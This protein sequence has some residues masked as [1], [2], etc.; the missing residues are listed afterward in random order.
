[1]KKR[2]ELLKRMVEQPKPVIIKKEDEKNGRN[3]RRSH[4]RSKKRT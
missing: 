3:D 1:M 4:S 2:G